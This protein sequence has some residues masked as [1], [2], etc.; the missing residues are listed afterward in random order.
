M[1]ITCISYLYCITLFFINVELIL[2]SLFHVLS[3]IY[4]Y[5]ACITMCNC[6]PVISTGRRHF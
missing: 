6:Q 2:A 1:L 5:F 4:R 3:S